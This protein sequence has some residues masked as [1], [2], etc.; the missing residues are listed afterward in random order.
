[1]IEASF[2]KKISKIILKDQ[3]ITRSAP[4]FLPEIYDRARH[5]NIEDLKKDLLK[6]NFLVTLYPHFSF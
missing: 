5:Q 6:S 3:M 4:L 1:M 2:Q